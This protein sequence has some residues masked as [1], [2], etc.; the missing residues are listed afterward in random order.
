MS[1]QPRFALGSN[2][3]HFFTLI[4]PTS[5]TPDDGFESIGELTRAEAEVVVVGYRFDLRTNELLPEK[6]PNP[7]AGREDRFHAW[8]LKGENG[9][10][11]VG[12]NRVTPEIGL[13]EVERDEE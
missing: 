11:Q 4:L 12:F 7:N 6:I 5:S 1:C 13:A 8:R 3:V 9:P 2:L 10:R